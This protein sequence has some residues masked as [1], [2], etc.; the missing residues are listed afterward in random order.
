MVKQLSEHDDHGHVRER[1]QPGLEVL[2]RDRVRSKLRA[3]LDGKCSQ[4]F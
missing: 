3:G 2:Q 1:F 4:G